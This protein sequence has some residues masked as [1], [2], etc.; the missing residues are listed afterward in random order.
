MEN[1]KVDINTIIGW[2]LISGLLFYMLYTQQQKQAEEELNTPQDTEV[3]AQPAEEQPEPQKIAAPEINTLPENDS[4]NQALIE[5]LKG[6][7]E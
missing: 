2:V 7:F 4:I 1:K 6:S 5:G 3:V